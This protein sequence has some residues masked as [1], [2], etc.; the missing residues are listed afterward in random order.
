VKNVFRI[1]GLILLTFLINFCKKDKPGFPSITT[2]DI[3]EISYTSAYSG[4]NVTNDGGSA[5]VSL[6]V[7]WNTSIEPTIENCENSEPCGNS[8]LVSFTSHIYQLSANTLYY[9][10]AYA[11]NSV[12][13]SYGNEVS[14][15]TPGTVTD[16]DDNIYNVVTIGYK[17]WFKENLKTTRLNDGSPIP[18]NTKFGELFET[19]YRRYNNNEVTNDNTFNTRYYWIA[20]NTGKLCPVG[21]HVP[22]D[23]EWTN[24]T[25]YLGGDIIAGGQLKET[26][27]T[28]W[29]SPNI[30]ATN[31]SGFT[32][33]PDG[34]SGGMS[35]SWLSSTK[36][37]GMGNP[38]F[39]IPYIPSTVGIV[40]LYNNSSYVV[41]SKGSLEDGYS[42][43]C[44]S[45]F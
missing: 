3:T 44:L 24:L 7:C 9:L 30:G 45:D 23:V 14:F 34:Y 18:L 19:A 15:T 25:N 37:P 38:F 27:T 33:L 39:G 4:G 35:G 1:L 40:K 42:V 8:D 11:T 16:I 36:Y 13:T 22:T 32:A 29:L 5:I 41:R 43:R 6:G 28:H 10:R 2:T 12:G 21:W 26:G 17:T 20:I 31:E